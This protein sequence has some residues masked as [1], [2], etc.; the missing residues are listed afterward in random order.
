MLVVLVVAGTLV[1]V[2]RELPASDTPAELLEVVCVLEEARLEKKRDPRLEVPLATVELKRAVLAAS[3]ELDKCRDD[4]VVAIDA[5]EDARVA[6]NEVLG[7]SVPRVVERATLELAAEVGVW[8]ELLAED[9]VPEDGVL[10]R[11][12][13]ELLANGAI[14]PVPY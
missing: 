4:A 1:K 3:D 11:D 13:R 12:D 7:E 2:V 8:A 14:E 5:S 6:I 9:A 10:S